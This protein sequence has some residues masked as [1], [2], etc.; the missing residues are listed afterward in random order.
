[1]I[2]AS[3]KSF[4]GHQ[5]YLSLVQLLERKLKAQFQRSQVVVNSLET[6]LQF[7]PEA[8][9]KRSPLRPYWVIMNYR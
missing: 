6:M 3:T 2:K 4:I 9:G 1:M 5:D 7:D 8:R